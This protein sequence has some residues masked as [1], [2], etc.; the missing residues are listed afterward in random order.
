[1]TARGQFFETGVDVL[2]RRWRESGL[3]HEENWTYR[4]CPHSATLLHGGER[5]VHP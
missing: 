2:L 3:I 1:L 4:V 5:G